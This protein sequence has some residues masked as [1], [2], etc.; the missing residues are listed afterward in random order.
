[1]A[2][3][4][5]DPALKALTGTLRQDREPALAE[6]TPGG[7]MVVPFM[8]SD[9]AQLHFKR[10]AGMLGGEGR[11]SPHHADVV[12]LLAQRLEQIEMFQSVLA[13]EGS[14]YTTES[15]NGTMY[16]ARPEVVLL[17]DAMRHAQSL[18]SELMLS[19]T[20]LMRLGAPPKKQAGGFD[21]F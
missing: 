11:C 4:R 1:M 2:R 5:K 17:A 3:P 16:R 13:I 10:I 7:E 12:A 19:P 14:T 8:L 6:G 20:A 21:D 9:L 18:L 15:K